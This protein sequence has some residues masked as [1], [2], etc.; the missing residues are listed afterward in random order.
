MEKKKIAS[1]KVRYE[2]GTTEW[3]PVDKFVEQVGNIIAQQE[4]DAQR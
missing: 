2:D 3:M 1:V 4:A